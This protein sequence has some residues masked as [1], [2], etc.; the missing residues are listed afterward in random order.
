MFQILVKAI[1]LDPNSKIEYFTMLPTHWNCPANC[2]ARDSVRRNRLAIYLA[3]NIECRV[4]YSNRSHITPTVSSAETKFLHCKYYFR[5]YLSFS[6]TVYNFADAS[7]D[8]DFILETGRLS[9]V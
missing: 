6:N 9:C 1:G 7:Q 3:E 4:E 5:E 2:E 8:M